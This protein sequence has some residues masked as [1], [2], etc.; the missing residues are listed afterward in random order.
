M[1][2]GNQGVRR[3]NVAPQ[4]AFPYTVHLIQDQI[5]EGEKVM[6]RRIGRG[7]FLGEILGLPPPG[8]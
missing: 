4:Q 7:T 6:T 8:R 5:A 2:A 3:A 1:P